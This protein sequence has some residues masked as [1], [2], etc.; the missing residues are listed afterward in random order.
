MRGKMNIQR[1]LGLAFLIGAI[2][3]PLVWNAGSTSL[4]QTSTGTEVTAQPKDK[5]PEEPKIDFEVLGYETATMIVP[6]NGDGESAVPITV[7][8]KSAKTIINEGDWAGYVAVHDDSG[9][10]WPSSQV[11]VGILHV[12]KEPLQP[13]TA[14][15]IKITFK[16]EA[17]LPRFE[18]KPSYAS[19]SLSGYLFLR[20]GKTHISKP[21]PVQVVTTNPSPRAKWL[22]LSGL[23]AGLLI[24]AFEAAL[25]RGKL[26]KSIIIPE[27]GAGSVMTNLTLI[28]TVVTGLASAWSLIKQPHLLQIAEYIVLSG[29]FGALATIA[30]LAFSSIRLSQRPGP[31]VEAPPATSK[32][33]LFLVAC[34]F[35]I[36]GAFGQG[37]LIYYYFDEFA[38]AHL[39]TESGLNV[40]VSGMIVVGLLLGYYAIS[41]IYSIASKSLE[42]EQIPSAGPLE[43]HL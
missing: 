38:R 16:L 11:K 22:I 12:D 13:T 31:G 10:A 36:W 17:A 4:G 25:L 21:I 15:E 5:N 7:N 19:Q 37:I 30:P 18:N 40:I 41:T 8:N 33:W 28:G 43:N 1:I 24:L 35:T 42:K 34:L 26:I 3:V 27:W 20:A 23:F 14:R 29:L 32:A 2:G 39:V 6:I 9:G